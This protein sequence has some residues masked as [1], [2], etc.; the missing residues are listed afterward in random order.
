MSEMCKVGDCA[1]KIDTPAW[2]NMGDY[3]RL[4]EEKLVQIKKHPVL[5]LT[6]LNYT[7]KTQITVNIEISINTII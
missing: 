5:P 2:V 4:R 6:L 3:E 7:S 1:S